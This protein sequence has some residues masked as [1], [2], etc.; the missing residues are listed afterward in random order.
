MNKEEKKM[1]K[2]IEIKLK[3]STDTEATA[4]PW[5]MVIDPKQNFNTNSDGLRAIASMITGPFF[6]R[7]AAEEYLKR[8]AYAFSDNARVYCDSGYHADQYNTAYKTEFQA[9]REATETERLPAYHEG[10]RVGCGTFQRKTGLYLNEQ[11]VCKTCED[12]DKN[13]PFPNT[14]EEF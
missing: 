3:V 11:K 12:S 9:V 10:K 4:S 14:K 7:E 8:R 13:C 1:P 6:S 5:W 2:E